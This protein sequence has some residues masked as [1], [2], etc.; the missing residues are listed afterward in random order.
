MNAKKDRILVIV[1]ACCFQI[2]FIGLLYQ[3]SS[4]L[5]AEIRAEYGFPMTRVSTFNALRA[6]CGAALSGVYSALFFRVSK[7]LTLYLS[8][9]MVT[10]G[11]ALMTVGPDTW[12]WYL[13]SVILSATGPLS[14]FPIPYIIKS[15]FPE[16]YGTLS[17]LV[18]S[19]SGIGGMIFTPVITRMCELWGW[20]TADLIGCAMILL[21]GG[22][23]I[24]LIFRKPFPQAEPGP[25][26]PKEKRS[27]SSGRDPFPIR[28]FLICLISLLGASLFGQL[29]I[30]MNMYGQTYGFTL[31]QGAF[32]VSMVSIG[33]IAGKMVYGIVCDRRGAWSATI[34]N[35]FCVLTGLILLVFFVRFYPL[36]LLGGFL[37]GFTSSLMT[38]G[39]SRCSI[40]AYGEKRS[41]RYVGLHTGIVC[42]LGAAGSWSFGQVFDRF[43]D[44]KPVMIVGICLLTVSLACSFLQT[45]S[46]SNNHT[47]EETA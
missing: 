17:G 1:G 26:V 35:N 15:W 29:M 7:R 3:A 38:L 40:A 46:K 23:G 34:L 47:G 41:E 5:F 25:V 32:A 2:A 37:I 44:F 4:T 22:G 16:N 9:V 18:L 42:A 21:L 12:I 14:V 30:Y 31:M 19:G 20:R 45:R 39:V 43:G 36:F 11:Y 33:N 27:L 28:P 10:L 13:S 6:V 8:I 24:T